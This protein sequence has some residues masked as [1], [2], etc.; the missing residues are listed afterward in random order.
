MMSVLIQNY[1]K[2]RTTHHF[3]FT[4]SKKTYPTIP[5]WNKFPEI[6][7]VRKP[8]ININ[9]NLVSMSMIIVFKFRMI[10]RKVDF[11]FAREPFCLQTGDDDDNDSAKMFA[12]V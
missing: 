6:F 3:F 9:L 4:T 12:V 5:N 11:L 1:S 7:R 2:T 8:Q 10:R